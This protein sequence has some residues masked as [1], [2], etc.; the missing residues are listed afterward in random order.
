[1]HLFF[2][3]LLRDGV[4]DWPFLEG[5]G[6]GS[7]ATTPGALFAIPDKRGWYPAL[8]LT[9]A[10]LAANVVGT[11]HDAGEVDI[12]AIDAFEGKK[13]QRQKVPVDGWSGYGDT[14]AESYIWTGELPDD[15]EPILH[16]DFV[17]WL[18][19]NGYDPYVA[20]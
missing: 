6:L 12:A 4:G 15:A 10:K 14:H 2:Y 1:M 17:K 19:E 3:G 20:Q 7:P 11:I 18:E 16:G 9:Q 8:V 13:Y 5:L